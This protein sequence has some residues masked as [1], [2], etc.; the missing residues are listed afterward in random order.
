MILSPKSLLSLLS[1]AIIP[2]P[3]ELSKSLIREVS[4]IV[5][6]SSVVLYDGDT[7]TDLSR[8]YTWLGKKGSQDFNRVCTVVDQ[9]DGAPAIRLSGE[10]WGGIVTPDSYSRY[11][12]V[13]EFRWGSIT[14]EPRKDMARKSGILIHCQGADGN[15][16]P[17]FD[18]PWIT[19]VEFEIY[20]GR[21]G[22]AV[23]VPGYDSPDVPVRKFPR[24][25]M[26]ALRGDNHWNP[27]G[28]PQ[29]FVSGK[30]RMHWF[31]KDPDWENVLGYRGR[32]DV[33]KPSGEWNRLEAIVDGGDMIFLVNGVK[34]MEL[35]DS[36][37][38]HGRIFF[39]SESAE[40]FFRRIELHPLDD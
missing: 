4:P 22:D 3:A 29:E 40:V 24:A 28:T 19:S 35:T 39:Q 21:T 16:T 27:R 7:V 37:L 6:K 32:N 8:F 15:F 5:L 38:S 31:G 34:V 17:T 30:G 18:S 14:W 23:L 20:D 1:L 9:V 33:E 2:L 12:L 25:T 13:T 11:R 26:R 36:S 10:D